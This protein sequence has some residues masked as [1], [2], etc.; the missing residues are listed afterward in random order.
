MA[1]AGEFGIWE[2]VGVCAACGAAVAITEYAGLRGKWEDVIV[3]TVL[4]FVMLIL[5]YR[6]RWGT[7]SFWWKL[8][9]IFV[10]HVVA[11]T[12]ILQSVPIGPHGIPGLLMTVITMAGA[13]VVI[14][15]LDRKKAG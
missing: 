11:T 15:L 4:L 1:N 14:V 6:P 13:L 3:F 7:I 10:L 9:L 5:L 8:F 2:W 12:I